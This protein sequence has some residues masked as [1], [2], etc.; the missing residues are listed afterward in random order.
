[1]STSV[2]GSPSLIPSASAAS[3]APSPSPSLAAELPITSPDGLELTSLGE[4]DL[5]EPADLEEAAEPS[6]LPVY[7]HWGSRFLPG[8]PCVRNILSS[9]ACERFSWYGLIP[10]LYFFFYY[11]LNYS[12]AGATAAVAWVQTMAYLFP[13]AGGFVADAMLDKFNT[14]MIFSCFYVL[15]VVLIT[16]S[17]AKMSAVMAWTG[18]VFLCL[19]TGGI[20][21]NVSVFGADQFINHDIKTQKEA[22]AQERQMATY[23]NVRTTHTNAHDIKCG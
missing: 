15:G 9:E 1:M 18:M 16:I 5:K 23:Y 12:D 6:K 11:V 4:K 13:L 22:D 14:I 20:K 2:T 19:G 7:T 3:P 8:P 21:P 10:Q 17:A